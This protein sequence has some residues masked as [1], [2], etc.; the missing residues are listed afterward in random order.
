MKQSP[1]VADGL[2]HLLADTYLLYLKT[3]NFHWNV[4]GSHFTSLHHLFEEQYVQLTEAADLLAERIR[5]LQAIAPGS[6]AEFLELTSLKEASG[7]YT[8]NDMVASLLKDHEAISSSIERLLKSIENEG[9]E[10]TTDMLIQRK[11]EHDKT[12]WMLRSA[13]EK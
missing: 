9:D 7:E 12:A 2:S 10:V 13:L 8:A 6:F 1:L 4:T 3:Q 5:A 11:T